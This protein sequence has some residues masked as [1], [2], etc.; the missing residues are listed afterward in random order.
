MGV[1]SDLWVMWWF[2]LCTLVSSNNW[3]ASNKLQYGRNMTM[4]KITI[5]TTD[6]LAFKAISIR[7]QAQSAL[8]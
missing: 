1:A 5:P 8:S 4:I 6:G 7:N 3:L 2:L